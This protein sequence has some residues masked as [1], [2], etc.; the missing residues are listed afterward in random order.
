VYSQ[1]GTKLLSGSY[2]GAARL[3]D[4]AQGTSR[5]FRGHDWWVWSVA[6]SPDEKR[7]VTA[8]QDG[9]AIV[10]TI[11]TGQASPPFLA[12]V[13]PVYSA[14]F[15]PDGQ[16]V[17]TGSYDKRVLLWRPDDL[18]TQ[19]IDRLLNQAVAE[20]ATE[21]STPYVAL[22]EHSAGVRSVHFSSD[23]RLLVSG[24]NDN[25]ICVWDVASHRMVKKLRGHASRVSTVLFM[26]G[27]DRLLSAAYDHYAKLWNISKY[28]EVR[29]LGGRVLKGHRD[30]VLAAAF[31]PDGK[32]VVTA[33]RDRSA[34]AWDVSSGKRMRTFEEGHA[35]L[36]SSALFFP[37][38]K[39]VLT[40]AVDNTARKSF[41]GRLSSIT[42]RPP[43]SSPTNG[44]VP[45]GRVMYIKKFS[46]NSS[47][48]FNSGGSVMLLSCSST[49]RW[50]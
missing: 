39:R 34:I 41:G 17:A 16:H 37:D 38:G 26:P 31:S 44:V 23:G 46:S 2:D 45:S 20:S 6:F 50:V 28:E 7:F 43:S 27:N 11:A 21:S 19:S 49:A 42:R 14:A 10:W 1:D 15:S 48:G 36:A 35:Y 33:S 9:S 12:H 3:W 22:E 24:G 40:A 4:V 47:L 8:S 30:S 18:K 5:E 29:V 25:N 13:G 32:T